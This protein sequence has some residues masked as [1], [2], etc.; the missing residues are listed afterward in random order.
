MFSKQPRCSTK[1][2]TQYRSHYSTSSVESQYLRLLQEVRSSNPEFGIQMTLCSV[3]NLAAI[4]PGGRGQG[5][6]SERLEKSCI[7][8]SACRIV[9]E[10]ESPAESAHD[11]EFIPY[12]EG[13]EGLPPSG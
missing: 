8:K 1:F 12:S 2:R 6:S 5:L 3:T 4:S 9:V 10:L 7:F 13:P 11:P